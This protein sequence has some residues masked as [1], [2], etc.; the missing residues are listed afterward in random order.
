MIFESD[1]VDVSAF[2]QTQF[3]AQVAAFT[4]ALEASKGKN[5][6]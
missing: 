2:D 1:M 6:L 5:E 4:E 3:T